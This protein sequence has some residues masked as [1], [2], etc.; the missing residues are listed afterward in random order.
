MPDIWPSKS[1]V[2]IIKPHPQVMYYTTHRHVRRIEFVLLLKPFLVHND[3]GLL[4][5]RVAQAAHAQQ[6]NTPEHQDTAIMIF[7]RKM[8]EVHGYVD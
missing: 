3:G 7:F 8:T 1:L 2:P 4:Q 6:L 5:A